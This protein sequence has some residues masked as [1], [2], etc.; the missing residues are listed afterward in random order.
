MEVQLND[1]LKLSLS[2]RILW[3]EALWNSIA[4]EKKSA[5]LLEISPEHKK[6]LDEE[7]ALYKKDPEAGS[8][9]HDV[10]AR[11]QKKK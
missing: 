9:W 2:E 7:I 3:V 4:A 11:I 8:S 1:I 6:I 5:E 10:K